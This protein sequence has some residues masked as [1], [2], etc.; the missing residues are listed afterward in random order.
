M[1]AVISVYSDTELIVGDTN[2]IS[3]LSKV[4]VTARI[5]SRKQAPAYVRWRAGVKQRG[6]SNSSD[7]SLRVQLI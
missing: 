6:G 1:N 4:A 7:L 3:G 5:T 2:L